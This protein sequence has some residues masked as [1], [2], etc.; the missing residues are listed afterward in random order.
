[1]CRKKRETHRASRFFAR[2]TLEFPIIFAPKK[3]IFCI[4]MRRVPTWFFMNAH[5]NL[6]PFLTEKCGK[7]TSPFFRNMSPCFTNK[8]T[9]IRPFRKDI[10]HTADFDGFP[11]K[12]TSMPDTIFE[13]I[14]KKNTKM[15][16]ANNSPRSFQEISVR[17][18]FEPDMI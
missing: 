9:G 4:M 5:G 13:K 6:D 18:Q 3:C 8:L 12:A 7:A 10:S 14:Q 16:I 1:M 2:F 17:A 11:R 15:K